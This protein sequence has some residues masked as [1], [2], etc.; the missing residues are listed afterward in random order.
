MKHKFSSI[1]KLIKSNFKVFEAPLKDNLLAE[2]GATDLVIFVK[3]NVGE[4]FYID[5]P[6][7]HPSTNLS[8]YSLPLKKTATVGK[9]E[10]IS[11]LIA[12]LSQYG[13]LVLLNE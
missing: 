10:E 2:N 12:L 1:E 6:L 11:K 4:F 7:P 8:V 13:L 5:S 3:N 9:N